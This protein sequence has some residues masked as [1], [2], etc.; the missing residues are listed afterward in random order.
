[1]KKIMLI[2]IPF[3]LFSCNSE[4]I[5]KKNISVTENECISSKFRNFHE[6]LKN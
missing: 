2:I 5:N 3:F 6:K 1:M 4:K